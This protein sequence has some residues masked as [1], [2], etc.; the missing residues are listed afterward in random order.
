MR[1]KLAGTESSRTG[2]KLI[3][4]CSTLARGRVTSVCGRAGARTAMYIT[5]CAAREI[6]DATTDSDTACQID[7]EKSVPRGGGCDANAL[8]ACRHPPA[9]R[10][11]RVRHNTLCD[12][13]R[14][15]RT[16]H[17]L[18]NAAART[19]HLEGP[20]HD[21]TRSGHSI[22]TEY[23]DTREGRKAYVC[24]GVSDLCT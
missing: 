10:K 24:K 11:D 18:V 19:A 20:V 21:H 17:M 8:G 5:C 16:E 4:P 3:W 2:A 23:G 22:Q 14:P 6:F 1:G 7:S 13:G 15:R 9:T 12:A